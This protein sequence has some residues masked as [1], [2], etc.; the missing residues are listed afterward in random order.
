MSSLTSPALIK[1]TNDALVKI[2]SDM[3]II[4]LFSYDCSDAVSDYGLKVKVPIVNGTGDTS[5]S[6]FNITS[7]DYEKITGTVTYAEVSLNKQPKATFEFTGKDILEA[8]NAPYWNRCAE[9]AAE[10]VKASISTTIGGLLNTTAVTT[11]VG[12]ASVTKASVAS[13]RKSCATRVASTVLGLAPDEYSTLL[14]LL[15]SS[16]YGDS[17]PVRTGYISNLY[18]F[19][20]VIQLNDLPDGVLGALLPDNSLA[21]AS[22]AV[23]VGDESCYSEIGTTT[24]ENGFTLTTLRHGSPAKGKGFLNVTC[25]YGATIIPSLGVKLIVTNDDPYA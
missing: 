11:T 2:A 4:R 24:D 6:D 1:A 12:I 18:G 10:V 19:K 25:L 13:L 8:P 21:F 5:V 14:S 15:D 3:N 9:G 16:V 17:D 20:A 23:A 7:N 22:R